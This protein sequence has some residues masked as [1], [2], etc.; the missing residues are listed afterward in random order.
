MKKISIPTHIS[1]N[2]TNHNKNSILDQYNSMIAV[3]HNNLVTAKYSMTL[4]QKRI[5]IWLISQIQPNDI[6][7]KEH[8]LDIK[9]LINICKLSGESSYK[10]IK[11]ITFSLI[12]KGVRIIDI[13]NNQYDKEI[14]VSWLSSADYDQ[15][16]V[17]LSFNPKLKPY[18]LQLKQ[19]FTSI[20]LLDLMQFK[21]IY[22]IRIY[23]L[24][25]QYEVIGERTLLITDIKEYCGI[26]IKLNTYPNF[27]KRVLLISQREINN[28]S[29][30]KFEFKRIKESRKFVAI[31]FLI[32]R[33]KAYY[34]RNQPEQQSFDIKRKPP[35]YDRLKE[36]GISTRMTN[37]LIKQ[38]YN[39][40]I[41]NALNAVD[42]QM[43]KTIV[44]N[45]KAMVISAIKEKWHPDKFIVRK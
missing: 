20:N 32:S 27:E 35:V 4:Q 26:K 36:F 22:A 37:N 1:T 39:D 11:K 28:K 24:L 21:S 5:M 12:E 42:I 7:F 40:T 19:K 29:D 31:K 3:Q 9:T 38:Y 10:E 18:L 43:S 14:Q 8:I 6:E 30:I 44:R 16:R 17:K 34:K 13:S 33:N 15:G 23:E 25:K 41:E 2:I 45:P